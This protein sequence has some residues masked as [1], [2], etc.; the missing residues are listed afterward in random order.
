[1]KQLMITLITAAAI[2][3]TAGCTD[4][5]LKTVTKTVDP[6]FHGAGIDGT[7]FE[8]V[9]ERVYSFHWNWY[10]NLIIDTDDGLVVIDPMNPTLS[11]ALKQEL[12]QRFPGRKV[13]TLIYSHYHLDHTGGGAVLQPG[14]V[15]AH[16]KSAVCWDAV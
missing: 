11:A 8:Q 3:T 4:V 2:A 12:D 9:A 15:I 16:E 1:M 7:N 6:Y 10:R 13:H 5:V 14:Q